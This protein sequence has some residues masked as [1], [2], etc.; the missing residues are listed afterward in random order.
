[1]EAVGGGGGVTVGVT[2][3]L[4]STLMSRKWTQKITQRYS[5]VF[6]GELGR[7]EQPSGRK[8]G[9]LKVAVYCE[10]ALADSGNRH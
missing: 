1:M 9:K 5:E 10:G 4:C 3:W 2:C 7:D 6:F 8:M